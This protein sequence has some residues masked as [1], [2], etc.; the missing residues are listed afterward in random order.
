MQGYLFGRGNQQLSAA[1][2]D[3][4]GWERIFILASSAKLMELVPVQLHVDFSEP[5]VNQP[6]QFMKVNTSV[7]R[8]V[9]CRLLHRVASPAK[10]S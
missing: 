9:V 7:T 5:L 4:I 10:E 2:V 3:R 6:P 1:V 8:S